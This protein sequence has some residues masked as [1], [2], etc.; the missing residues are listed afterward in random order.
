MLHIVPHCYAVE[1]ES[2]ATLLRYQLSS[3]VFHRPQHE[4]RVTVCCMEEDQ[5]VGRVLDDF[6]SDSRI[7]LQ[8][9]HL[10]RV[11]I[12]R[13]TIGRNM[14]AKAS[15]AELIW[16][17]DCDYVFGPGCLDGLVAAWNALDEWT[18]LLYPV[19]YWAHRDHETGDR[20][21]VD[22]CKLTHPLLAIDPTEFV[23]ARY[24]KAI[25]GIQI[26]PGSFCRVHGYL[27]DSPRNHRPLDKPLS[28]TRE[29][30]AFRSFCLQH[31]PSVGLKFPNLYRLRHSFH[32]GQHR[33]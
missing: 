32:L 25:G 9:L 4:V 18:P 15:Q 8:V 29:D 13:R 31:G 12:S 28:S 19:S 14:V 17:A 16:F 22:A 20:A 3:L 21:V 24:I 10:T 6:L 7:N 23:L 26:C 5:A 1:I 11:Q 27:A 33:P 30:V 2:Y